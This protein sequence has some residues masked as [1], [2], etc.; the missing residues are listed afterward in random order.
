MACGITKSDIKAIYLGCLAEI[1]CSRKISAISRIFKRIHH[2]EILF[3]VV[4]FRCNRFV[5]ALIAFDASTKDTQYGWIIRWSV[6]LSTDCNHQLWTL[7][8]YLAM[9]YFINSVW[10][11]WVWSDY[12]MY[13]QYVYAVIEEWL[14]VRARR[15]MRFHVSAFSMIAT[16][17]MPMY[18]RYNAKVFTYFSWYHIYIY[19]HLYILWE[20]FI[21]EN[22]SIS[23][24]QFMIYS[25]T[26]NIYSMY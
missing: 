1:S 3:T 6:N 20:L 24:K 12:N 19:L 18:F 21:Y 4:D 17:V 13:I 10:I 16:Y 9:S 5:F 11:D 8:E 2:A 26:Y 23:N 14:Y 7:Y 25:Y 22:K 15:F